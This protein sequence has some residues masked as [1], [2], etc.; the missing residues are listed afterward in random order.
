MIQHNNK[1]PAMHRPYSP[2]FS[3]ILFRGILYLLLNIISASNNG[4]DN[5]FDTV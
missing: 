1:M 3:A 5:A 4:L 2:E